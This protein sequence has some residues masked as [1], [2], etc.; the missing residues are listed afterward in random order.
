MGVALF[1]SLAAGASG[2]MRGVHQS[3]IIS[4]SLLLLSAILI[5]RRDGLARSKR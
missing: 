2:F 4:A 5:W 3:L 1:G